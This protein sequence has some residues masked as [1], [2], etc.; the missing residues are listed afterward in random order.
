MEHALGLEA[1]TYM[2]TH[3][4]PPPHFPGQ[5]LSLPHT[6]HHQELHAL[7]DLPSLISTLHIENKPPSS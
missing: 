3:V 7:P 2:L 6:P 1:L 4:L 5:A